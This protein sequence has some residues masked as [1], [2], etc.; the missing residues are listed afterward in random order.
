M[1]YPPKKILQ[2]E[3]PQAEQCSPTSTPKGSVTRNPNRNSRG[4]IFVVVT[5]AAW[6]MGEKIKQKKGLNI[7]QINLIKKIYSDKK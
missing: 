5:P 3:P 7:E 6:I 1:D 4:K 2:T